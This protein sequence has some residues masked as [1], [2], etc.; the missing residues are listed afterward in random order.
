MQK[1]S[2]QLMFALENDM[3]MGNAVILW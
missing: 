1:S 3:V 2:F